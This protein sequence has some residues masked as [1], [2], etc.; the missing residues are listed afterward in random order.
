MTLTDDLI[1]SPLETPPPEPNP[2]M[3]KTW[4]QVT[5]G[6]FIIVPFAA[7]M[8]S[9][10]VVWGWGLNWR[11]VGIAI[12][13]Y[14]I[15]GHGITVGFHRYFTHSAFKATRWLRVTLAVAGSM[16][17][18]GPVIQWVA[19]HRKHHR[20]SDKNGDPHSPWRYGT[21]LAALTKG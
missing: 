2:V 4:E 11:D 8:A 1:A 16:A 12:V 17:I 7:V 9:I 5:L 20:F 21:N 3:K 13:M 14:A 18:Q 15:T 19:D 10:P 6:L